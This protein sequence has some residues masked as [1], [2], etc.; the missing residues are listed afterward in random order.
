MSANNQQIE[1]E[2][3]VLGCLL[4]DNDCF[5]DID[6]KT[7]EFS[8]GCHRTI[9]AAICEFLNAGKPVDLILLA[10]YLDK[11]GAL[12]SVGNLK[13]IGELVQNASSTRTIKSHAKKI[14]E[15]HKR[16]KLKELVSTLS[17]MVDGREDIDK[18]TEAAEAGLTSLVDGSGEETFSHIKKA[19][20]DAIEWEDSDQKG[21]STGLRDLDWMTKGFKNSELIIIAGRPS[22]GKSALAFQIA[23]HVANKESVI[24]FS[25]EMSSRQV[26]SRF[27][28]FHE[29]RVGKSQ[30]ISHLYALN[31]HIEEKP[32]VTLGHIRSKCREVKRK[33][34]LSMIVVDYLQLMQGEGDNRN[35]EIGSLSRGLKGLAKEFDI[36]VVVL[37]QLSRKVDDRSDKRPLMSDLR[38]SGEIEQDADVILFIYREE[39]YDK[40]CEEK[41]F[42]EIICR[43]NR[44][45]SIGEVLTKFSGEL[46]RFTDCNGERILRSVKPTQATRAFEDGL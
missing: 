31:L 1:H 17:D 13:Y 24:I 23:E 39:V 10:E 8:V 18:I 4:R 40:F 16:R 3:T 21:L 22:M 29:S 25:L 45:G 44:N 46:T 5:D 15:A 26:A 6:L 41:G 43:K 33:Q 37:S 7:H 42:A 34:G 36:P 14:S 38:E 19:V 9:Y 2:Q 28:K 11:H 32:S 35:Q 27:M 30:A 20:A 12:E